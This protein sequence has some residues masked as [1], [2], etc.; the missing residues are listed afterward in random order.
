MLGVELMATISKNVS[1]VGFCEVDNDNAAIPIEYIS[2]PDDGST[3]D[4]MTF[5]KNSNQCRYLSEGKC[6]K[7]KNCQNL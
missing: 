4:N 1:R 3:K 5:I 2:F 6:H 7:R